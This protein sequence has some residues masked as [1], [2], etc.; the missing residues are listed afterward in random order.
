VSWL[1]ETLVELLVE[2]SRLLWRNLERF[3]RW[4]VFVFV[5]GLLIFVTTRS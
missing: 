2:S 5:V 1:V 4:V 3:W